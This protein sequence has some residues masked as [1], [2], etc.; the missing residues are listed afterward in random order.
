M[1][2]GSHPPRYSLLVT[3]QG[4]LNEP[5]RTMP[6]RYITFSVRIHT[7]AHTYDVF[8]HELVGIDYEPLRVQ[9]QAEAVSGQGGGFGH[10]GVIAPLPPTISKRLLLAERNDDDS[11]YPAATTFVAAERPTAC[12][13]IV[14]EQRSADTLIDIPLVP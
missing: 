14:R 2:A 10:T 11:E 6:V 7:A 4:F 9:V 5:A 1:V 13:V 3:M 8:L 12:D